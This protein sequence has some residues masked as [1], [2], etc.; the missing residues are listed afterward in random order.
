[1]KNEFE[2]WWYVIGNNN[3]AQE[4]LQELWDGPPNIMGF[5]QLAWKTALTW[6]YNKLQTDANGFFEIGKELKSL[7]QQSN[8]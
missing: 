1:M 6:A 2:E 5:A 4:E 8:D 7:S 3:Y